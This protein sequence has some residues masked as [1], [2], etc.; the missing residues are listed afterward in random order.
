MFKD[1]W[2]NF[3]GGSIVW[4]L[5]GV[6]VIA[7]KDN[8]FNANDYF[9]FWFSVFMWVFPV[10]IGYCIMI[11]VD[12]FAA[13]QKKIDE[14]SREINFLKNQNALSAGS[15]QKPT[16]IANL[17]KKSV[18]QTGNISSAPPYPDTYKTTIEAL[19]KSL[20]WLHLKGSVIGYKKSELQDAH[21]YCTVDGAVV[22]IVADGAGSK[23]FSKKGADYCVSAIKGK[24]E[25]SR[26]LLASIKYNEWQDFA[27]K[28]LYTVS[29]GLA[30]LAKN[31]GIPVSELGSTCILV[32]ANDNFTACSHVGDGR[33]GYL[34]EDGV[35]KSLM[36]PFKGSEANA[37][38]FMTSLSPQNKEKYILTNVVPKRVRG[39]VA[40][41]DGPESVCWNVS[42]RDQSGSKIVDPN[43]PAGLF[44]EKISNQLI[45]ASRSNTKQD[46]LDRLWANFLT[47]GNDALATQVDDKTIV[48]ALRG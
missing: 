31:E 44:F 9:A 38:I 42:T 18:Q 14:K 39:V 33:S 4:L 45:A 12:E 6:A 48:F 22:L 26:E 28:L 21:A 41:S 40:L 19:D 29:E 3:F 2:Q 27:S 13:F 5:A 37:T 30:E 47:S 32:F 23:K 8:V 7:V 11:I 34:D 1:K 46:E 43:L 25:A 36:T 16:G 24:I 35:W 15:T 20:G 17:V 10:V